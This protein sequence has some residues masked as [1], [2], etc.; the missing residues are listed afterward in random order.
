VL[1]TCALSRL[2]VSRRAQVSFAIRPPEGEG[3]M[4]RTRVL[5][6]VAIVAAFG[7]GTVTGCLLA[8]RRQP[9]GQPAV[10]ETP[11]QAAVPA[12]PT[13]PPGQPPRPPDFF[14][15]V[16]SVNRTE[17]GIVFQIR[18]TKPNLAGW[19]SEQNAYNRRQDWPGY[20]SVILSKD[21]P[22]HRRGG[23]SCELRVGQTVSAWGT[24]QAYTTNP[25]GYEGNFVVI[26]PD[27]R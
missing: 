27:D 10:P 2:R 7:A 21:T 1:L 25:P 5:V 24:G 14:G 23:G 22:I 12:T 15:R 11:G 18:S 17:Y 13:D 16:E 19:D 20:P 4:T 26:E 3:I 6:V 8:V 9:P